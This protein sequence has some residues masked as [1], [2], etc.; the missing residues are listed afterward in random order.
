MIPLPI[1][2]LTS[3]LPFEVFA[4]F[5]GESMEVALLEQLTRHA[6]FSGSSPIK[7]N[8]A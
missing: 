5:C 2:A 6:E 4:P 8:Q 1:I 3:P 7:P